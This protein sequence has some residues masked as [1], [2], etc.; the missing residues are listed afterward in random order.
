MRLII[1]LS[2]L[3]CI[4]LLSACAAPAAVPEVTLTPPLPT[5]QPT[6]SAVVPAALQFIEFYSPF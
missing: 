4:F 1:S 5:A 3:F 2:V 6:P